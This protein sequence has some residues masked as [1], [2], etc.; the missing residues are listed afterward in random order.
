MMCSVGLSVTAGSNVGLLFI[1]VQRK[2]SSRR[3][4]AYYWAVAERRRGLRG[5][6]G[7]GGE[8][9]GGC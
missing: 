5:E 2:F 4:G 6:E 3:S 7:R 9:G 8:G 1:Q